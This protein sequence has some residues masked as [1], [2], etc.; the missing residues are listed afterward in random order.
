MKKDLQ[1]FPTA[2][3][4]EDMANDI[5]NYGAIVLIILVERSHASKILSGLTWE[6]TSRLRSLLLRC[7]RYAGLYPH[8]KISLFSFSEYESV[9]KKVS[10]ILQSQSFKD[11]AQSIFT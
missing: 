2:K 8:T 9:L 6:E 5:A 1:T 4:K 7:L 10:D 11:A 3:S